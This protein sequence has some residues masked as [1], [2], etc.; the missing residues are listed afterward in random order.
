MILVLPSLES[1]VFC[2]IAPFL[3]CGAGRAFRF[4]LISGGRQTKRWVTPLL[5]CC[6][7]GIGSVAGFMAGIDLSVPVVF[8][9][10]AGIWRCRKREW[11]FYGPFLTSYL[12][13][14]TIASSAA[15]PGLFGWVGDWL[16]QVRNLSALREQ[17]ISSGMM[18]RTPVFAAVGL[19]FFWNMQPYEVLQIVA[20]LCGAGAIFV[21]SKM[22]HVMWRSVAL[23]RMTY[24]YMSLAPF[25]F[26]HVLALWSKCLAAG[27]VIASLLT[28]SIKSRSE[29]RSTVTSAFWLG[30]GIAV[31]HSSVTFFPMHLAIFFIK[32]MSWRSAL[33]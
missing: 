18:G 7:F 19:P 32:G 12:I 29:R 23:M 16:E 9:S 11:R 17:T 26:L 20:C 31:H 15:Y 5:G 3:I 6:V 8:V 30:C 25:Y 21:F 14:L 28:L 22:V 2:L 10:L 1:Y 24:L 33:R 4:D 13:L 27:C